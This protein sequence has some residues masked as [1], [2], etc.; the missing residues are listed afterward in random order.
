VAVCTA[1]LSHLGWRF[2][3][4]SGAAFWGLILDHLIFPSP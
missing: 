2:D 1:C 3:S 4:A